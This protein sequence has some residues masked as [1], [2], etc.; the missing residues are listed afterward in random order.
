MS[1]LPKTNSYLPMP[2]EVVD[3]IEEAPGINTLR[4]RLTDPVQ[5]AAYTFA[6]GQFN[7]LYLADVGEVPISISSDPSEPELIDHTIRAVG[8]VTEGMVRVKEGEIMGLR[9]PFGTGWPM[10]QAKGR[11]ILVITGGIGCAPTASVVGYAH[12][13]RDQYG[14]ITVLHGVRK[15][16]DLIYGERFDSWCRATDTVCMFASQEQA[17]GWGGR[18]GLVTELLN[19]LA[20]GAADGMIMMCGPEVMMRAVAE[21][22]LRRG[23]PIEDIYVSMERSMQCGLGHCGHCQYGPDFICKDGPV[24]PYAR[25]RRL[26]PVKGF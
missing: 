20:P 24:F 19:D 11:N 12:A 10:E 22:L 4:L 15:P 23:R 5:R 18:T 9:G 25:V 7:M 16:S 17:P 21:E 14:K 8:R 3:N 2:A 13:R 6:P 1:A 26:M